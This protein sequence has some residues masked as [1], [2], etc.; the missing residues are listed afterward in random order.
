MHEVNRSANFL[1]RHQ[2]QL[3]P[4]PCTCNTRLYIYARRILSF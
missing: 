1:C 3:Y 4:S 2:Y